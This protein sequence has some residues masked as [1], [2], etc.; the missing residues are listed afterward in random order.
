[1]GRAATDQGRSS[2]SNSSGNSNT[3][4]WL[5]S[6][7]SKA[8]AVAAAK[9]DAAADMEAVLISSAVGSLHDLK[10]SLFGDMRGSSSSLLKH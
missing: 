9:A 10:Q 3:I 4:H 6:Q 1:M 2:N 8:A 5:S 7:Q